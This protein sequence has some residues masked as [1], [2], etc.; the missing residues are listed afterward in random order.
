MTRRSAAHQPRFDVVTYDKTVLAAIDALRGRERASYDAAKLDLEAQGCRQA[1]YRM[2]AE[3]GGPSEYCCKHLYGE[4]RL[5]TTFEDR[6]VEIVAIGR[7]D[8]D[9][10]YRRLSD[11]FGTSSVGQRRENKP[12]CCDEDGWQ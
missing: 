6:E 11:E 3:D 8:G 9:D 1:G 12:P 5:M 4:L 7:H 2:Q 10:F